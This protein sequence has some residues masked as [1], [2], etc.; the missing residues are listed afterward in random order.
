MERRERR[1]YWMFGLNLA[2]NQMEAIA[3]RLG[4]AR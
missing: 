4:A 1:A 2:L 3:A